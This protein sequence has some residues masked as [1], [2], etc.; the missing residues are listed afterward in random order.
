M[1]CMVCRSGDSEDELLI[2]DTCEQSY[3]TFCLDTPLP[4]IPPG[5]WSCPACVA[6]VSNPYSHN[7]RKFIDLVYILGVY[8]TN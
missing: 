4:S 3:H 8:Q 7:L 1:K 6:A 5:S 2:C